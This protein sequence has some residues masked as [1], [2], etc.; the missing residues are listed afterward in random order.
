MRAPGVPIPHTPVRILVAV[1]VSVA[2]TIAAGAGDAGDAATD[3]PVPDVPAV[4]LRGPQPKTPVETAG[5]GLAP[6]VSVRIDVDATGS[7]STV[8]VLSIR[9]STEHD[10]AFRAAVIET[11]GEWRF[12]PARLDGNAVRTRVEW[13]VDFPPLEERQDDLDTVDAEMGI[14]LESLLF[15]RERRDER[16]LRIYELPPDQQARHLERLLRAAELRI[17]APDRQRAKSDVFVVVT[18]VPREGVADT[19]LQN[20]N[21]VYATLLDMLGERIE[22]HGQY[23]PVYVYL[24]RSQHQYRDLA[25]AIDG[26]EESAGMTCPP[27]L[28]VLH[29]EMVANEELLATLIHE[30]THAFVLRQ[31]TRP[32]TGLPRW[33]SEGF[34]E[35]LSNSAIEKDR[36]VPGKIRRG[37]AYTV[38]IYGTF[39]DRTRARTGVVDVRRAMRRGEALS[40]TEL[41][42][43]SPREFYGEEIHLHYAQSWLL[44]HF[45]AHGEEEWA[46]REFLEFLLYVSEGYAPVD[47]ISRIYDLDVEQLEAAYVRYVKDL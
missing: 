42:E 41:L 33:L 45:L 12:A 39:L 37:Q 23:F 22:V 28:V 47:V 1:L 27:G 11:F 40:V 3:P 36:I 8:E 17:H 38:P 29:A 46:N 34:A 26:F 30:A 25:A 14:P 7:V 13:T 16:L 44:V 43:K 10:A 15:E 6:T 24:Y 18:D 31:L 35:Y 19:V 9:P 2:A 4:V 5:T 21:A 20:L 32:G